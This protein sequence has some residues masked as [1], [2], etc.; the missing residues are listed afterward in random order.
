MQCSKTVFTAFRAWTGTTRIPIQLASRPFRFRFHTSC[1][2][3][4]NLATDQDV[5]SISRPHPSLPSELKTTITPPSLSQLNNPPPDPQASANETSPLSCIDTRVLSRSTAQAVR[6][7]LSEQRIQDA[8]LLVRSLQES[9]RKYGEGLE[10]SKLLYR[11]YDAPIDFGQVVSPGLAVHS[12]LHGLMKMGYTHKAGN[13]AHQL[14]GAGIILKE[15]TLERL[16][17]SVGRSG[18]VIP[19]RLF[20]P[21]PGSLQLNNPNSFLGFSPSLAKTKGIRLATRLLCD[22]KAYKQRRNARMFRS[23]MDACLLQGEILVAT[24]L[25]AF[26]LKQY[27]L[28]DARTEPLIQEIEE[29]AHLNLEPGKPTSKWQRILNIPQSAYPSP[30]L[31]Y[32]VKITR[33][34]EDSISELQSPERSRA[35]NVKEVSQAM[36]NLATMLDHGL[37]PYSQI[38]SL[39][40]TLYNCPSSPPVKIAYHVSGRTR[41]MNAH[42]YCRSVV[43]R[44]LQRRLHTDKEWEKESNEHSDMEEKPPDQ[45]LP[46][47]KLDVYSSNSLIH[48]SLRFVRSPALASQ[49]FQR[50]KEDEEGP[51]PNISTYNILIRSSTLLRHND[52]T[53]NVV[54]FLAQRPENQDDENSAIQY[55][56]KQ[57]LEHRSNKDPHELWRSED[58]QLSDVLRR[59]ILEE[60]DIPLDPDSNGDAALQTDIYTL[61]SIICHLTA[62]GKPGLAVAILYKVIPEMDPLYDPVQLEEHSQNRE[63]DLK[64]QILMRSVT[65]GPWFF[66]SI[67]NAL[68]KA[69]KTGLATRVWALAQ[70]AEQWSWDRPEAWPWALHIHAYTVMM[71]IYANEALKGNVL[72]EKDPN[73]SRGPRPAWLPAW[74]DDEWRVRKKGKVI[75]WY[76]PGSPN[77]IKLHPLRHEAARLAGLR[78]FSSLK[79]KIL[80]V[81][82][83]LDKFIQEHPEVHVPKSMKVP[84]M[85]AR[86]FNAALDLY[87]RH[88]G[89]RRNTEGTRYLWRRRLRA[90]R[91]KYM[92]YG[93]RPDVPDPRILVILNHM[94]ECNIPI[95]IAYK[96]LLY[97]SL[98][99][100]TKPVKRPAPPLLVTPFPE[101][102]KIRFRPHALLTLKTRGMPYS[103]YNPRKRR[104]P[105]RG[106][107]NRNKENR[108][109]VSK[110]IIT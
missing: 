64:T 6:L 73:E 80:R 13:V 51:A 66:A 72:V 27:Q 32:M 2:R 9:G 88:P 105:R 21:S 39:I 99:S 82:Q 55:A 92:R 70:E 49:I 108:E 103:N 106:N 30:E 48:Y 15:R 45:A 28:H 53:K 23:L 97:G 41:H 35:V 74:E 60:F 8:F 89:Q 11:K 33:S 37:L 19:H 63:I 16:V 26:L 67:L 109:R 56:A 90:Y 59:A 50:M 101:T 20:K 104:G 96:P 94:Q 79:N 85:D 62:I 4:T 38:S 107:R 17:F 65:L 47:E 93:E 68:Q 5:A 54:N 14:M 71:R 83:Q 22:T 3:S 46:Q 34:I 52:T 40:K 31:R 76:Q 86:F 87:S 25:L 77:R 84:Y 95:P 44:F 91:G 36:A 7:A 110:W 69:G 58:T 18:G 98:E 42:S 61:N 100:Q 1:V 102:S 57:L 81:Q 78:L 10:P 24:F 43:Y 29:T 75:G 12:L